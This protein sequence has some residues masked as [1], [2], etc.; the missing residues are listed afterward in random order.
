M[1]LFGDVQVSRDLRLQKCMIRDH[2]LPCIIRDFQEPTRRLHLSDFT[3]CIEVEVKIMQVTWE[4]L[5]VAGHFLASW[6]SERHTEAPGW[7]IRPVSLI[8]A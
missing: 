1:D 6:A 8:S 2:L 7:N 3:S 5:T 4:K